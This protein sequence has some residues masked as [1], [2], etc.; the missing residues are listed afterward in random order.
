[1][2]HSNPTTLSV[3]EQIE[4]LTVYT[5]TEALWYFADEFM[6]NPTKATVIKRIK[7]KTCPV[8]RLDEQRFDEQRT[9]LN[10]IIGS[11]K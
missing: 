5:P 1:M 2:T 7:Y 4:I 6:E 8:I 9:K 3:D 11:D 10:K